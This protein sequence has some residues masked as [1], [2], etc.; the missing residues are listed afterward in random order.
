MKIRDE[1]LL[2]ISGLLVLAF[3][4]GVFVKEN[5]SEWRD[6]QVEFTQLVSE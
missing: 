4:I 2:L 1:I 6:Y 5:N 3:T